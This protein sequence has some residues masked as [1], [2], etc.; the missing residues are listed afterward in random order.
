M[1]KMVQSI[2][3]RLSKAGKPILVS[4]LNVFV[5]LI[6][7]Y[8]LNNQPLFTG[9]DLNQYAWME[10]LKNKMGLSEQ[11]DYS[12]ALFVNVSYDK[13]LIEKKDE[14]GM[15]VG[16]IDIT[17]RTK[18]LALLNI[19]DSTNQYRYI[20]LD[21]RFEKGLDSEADSALFAKIKN[22]KRI[23]V[24]NHLDVELADSCLSAKA[25]I[26]D[27][28]STIVATNFA[29]YKFLHAKQPSL[30][31][32]A[33]NDLTGRTITKHGLL[34]S[35]DRSLC[36]NSLF[37]K[38]PYNGFSEYS[39]NGE[40][41]YYN[42][43]CDL[44]ANYSG[45]DLSTL[46]KNKLVFIGDMVED[47]HDTYS[48]L[49]P[50]TVITY[51]AL[52]SLLLGEHMVSYT[53]LFFL[54]IIFFFISFS[55]FKEGSIIERIPF[56]RKSHSK[57]LHFFLPLIGYTFVLSVIVVVLNLLFN[58]TISIIVPSIYFTIQ[59]TIL[60]FKRTKI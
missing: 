29:R 59:K 11:V 22:M 14:F 7:S 4:L 27:Y 39:R 18:L 28:A 16:N 37:L 56:V 45:Q 41:S 42:M 38:F 23:V 51:H 53:L 50:G 58:V 54:A 40:K 24:A 57:L 34:Y 30:P 32:F 8:V 25:A 33:Y 46:A 19:L 5:L 47:V 44:L 49:K 35:C 48:G 20:I 36:Y 31:L 43:G 10:F 12:D 21:V 9:E 3:G 52:R 13:Q 60:N 2:M 17:D 26:S 1:E 15:P 6:F 55:L